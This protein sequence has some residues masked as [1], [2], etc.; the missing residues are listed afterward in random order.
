MDDA[1][2]MRGVERAGDFGAVAEREVDAERTLRL[3]RRVMASV[4]APEPSDFG[5]APRASRSAS[6]S[7]SRYCMTRKLSGPLSWPTS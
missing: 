2:A 6:V 1:A 3:S 4:A 5:R 7:P